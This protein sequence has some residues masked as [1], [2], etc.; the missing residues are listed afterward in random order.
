MRNIITGIKD[1]HF[2]KY[3]A[4]HLARCRQSKRAMCGYIFVCCHDAFDIKVFIK[5]K[6]EEEYNS[7]ACKAILVTT[8]TDSWPCQ[9]SD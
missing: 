6:E 9:L 3:D 7:R 1:N 5:K 2:S 4:T 8:E